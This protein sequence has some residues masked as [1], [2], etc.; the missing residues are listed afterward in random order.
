MALERDPNALATLLRGQYQPS[1]LTP[2]DEQLSSMI[3]EEQLFQAQEAI[4][5]QGAESGGAYSIPSRQALQQSGI[6]ELRKLFGIQ[7][8]AAQAKAYPN[9]VAGEYGLARERERS[10]GNVAAAK[11]RAEAEAANR[12]AQNQFLHGQQEREHAF[13]AG[14]GEAGRSSVASQGALNRTGRMDVAREG[15]RRAAAN[16]AAISERA[17]PSGGAMDYIKSLFGMGGA[18]AAPTAPAAG[19]VDVGTAIDALR[20][21]PQTANL[22]FQQL[23]ESGELEGATPDE[24]AQFQQMWGK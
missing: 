23:M 12:G 1:R 18:P 17:N 10:S 11:A 3:P 5:Q 6:A 4:G 7:Q 8:A 19:G 20:Q 22:T 13:R 14:E 21:H 15:T 24:M 2:E 9:Q 16:Q